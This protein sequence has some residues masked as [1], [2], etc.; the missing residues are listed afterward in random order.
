MIPPAQIFIP[1]YEGDLKWLEVCLR[2]ID[3]FWTSPFKP[4][5][6]ADNGCRGKISESGRDIRYIFRWSDGRRDQVYLKMIAD[7]MVD[8]NAETILFMDS[9]CLFTKPSCTADFCVN[10][11]PMVKMMSYED[12]YAKYPQH[13]QVFQGYKRAVF[14]CLNIGSAYEYMQVQPFLFFKDTVKEVRHEIEVR[15]CKPL[16]EVMV[17]YMSN[18]FSE[19]NFFGAYAHDQEDD[20]Y[21]FLTPEHWGEARMRQFHSYTQSPESEKEEID[22]ILG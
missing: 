13:A 8:D 7:T 18:M 22:R 12:V 1:T 15:N 6:A 21:C 17:L 2:S 19:F 11:R 14:E 3:K 4:I 5:I 9:D 10:D 16:Q 20:R